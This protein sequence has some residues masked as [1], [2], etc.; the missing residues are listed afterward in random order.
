M[1]VVF[2]FPYVLDR[3]PVFPG[4]ESSGLAYLHTRSP[5]AFCGAVTIGHKK[6]TFQCCPLWGLYV[7]SCVAE[8]QLP[9][10][11]P[12]AMTYFAYCVYPGQDLRGL[13]TMAM[14]S[15]VGMPGSQPSLQLASLPWV[16]VC[17]EVKLLF[18]QPTKSPNSK[19]FACATLWAYFFLPQGRSYFW[20]GLVP[21]GAACRVCQ[22]RNS[23]GV[24]STEAERLDQVCPQKIIRVEHV[25]LAR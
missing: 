1:W 16:Q 17:W 10:A 15:L 12:A 21:A 22:G 13:S 9:S 18:A 4:L 7:P 14:S 5:L 3:S 2:F 11:K 8:L 23:F 24:R 19:N 25:I 6:H 20:V